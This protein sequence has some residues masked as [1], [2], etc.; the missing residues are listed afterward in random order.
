M[1][2]TT[3]VAFLLLFSQVCFANDIS[4]D[5]NQVEQTWAKIYYGQLKSEQRSNYLLLL[6]KVSQLSERYSDSLE[7][8]VWQAIVIA[9]NAANES[10]FVALESIK[11]AKNILE[12]VIEKQPST[13]NGA[14]LVT[15]GTLYYMTP[16]WPVSFGDTDKAKALLKK[17]LEI[18]P[19]SIDSNYFYADYLLSEN[20]FE[21]AKK[22][23][24]LALNASVR[25]FQSYA[26]QQLKHEALLA[27]E[28]TQ[29]G[30]LDSERFKFLSL[31][32]NAKVD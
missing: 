20:Q 25:P 31:F 15:L 19:D 12:Q 1:N 13:L 17:A 3:I 23:F 28:K 8:K 27:L 26:D 5:I 18:N 11:K 10:P 30:K 6:K 14:A 9:S 22:Y 4:H 24:R 29:Q 2:K 16:G 7:L 21:A 32:S